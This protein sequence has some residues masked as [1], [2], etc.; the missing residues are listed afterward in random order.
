LLLELANIA[1]VP[2]EKK[3]EMKIKKSPGAVTSAGQPQ[4]TTIPHLPVPRE[5]TPVMTEIGP[6]RKNSSMISKA[7][8]YYSTWVNS[9]KTSIPLILL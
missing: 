4:P 1:K 6:K 2:R 8:I 5:S 9:I 3:K 7:V